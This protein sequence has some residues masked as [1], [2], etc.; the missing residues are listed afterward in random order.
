MNNYSTFQ[1]LK[2]VV[3]NEK[4]A[5]FVLEVQ[6]S[7]LHHLHNLKDEFNRY[8]PEYN[9]YET[10]SVRSMIRNPFI[11]KINEVPEIIRKI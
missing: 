10:K 8:F 1:T 7:V 5:D 2:S 9:G 3:D 4:Y 11:I 6:Q